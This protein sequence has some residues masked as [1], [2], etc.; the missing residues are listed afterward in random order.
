MPWV[1]GGVNVWIF[2]LLQDGAYRYSSSESPDN[3]FRQQPY[4]GSSAYMH[5]DEEINLLPIDCGYKH[6]LHPQT[7]FEWTNL[8]HISARMEDL[9]S[10]Y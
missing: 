8:Q 1:G 9:I 5:N 7:P 10:F 4:D 2:L 6:Q 3:Q